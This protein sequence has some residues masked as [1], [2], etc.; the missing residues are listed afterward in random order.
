MTVTIGAH[1]SRQSPHTRFPANN[2]THTRS[3]GHATPLITFQT[4]FFSFISA[5][6]RRSQSRQR[7]GTTKHHN[8][9]PVAAPHKHQ[10]TTSALTHTCVAAQTTVKTY[11]NTTIARGSTHVHTAHACAHPRK[12]INRHAGCAPNN[13]HAPHYCHNMNL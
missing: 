12:Y 10:P 1:G 5:Q 6:Q 8:S 9:R 2:T 7:G 13:V 4:Y 3:D 11:Y